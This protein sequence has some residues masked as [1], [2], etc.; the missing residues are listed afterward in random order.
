MSAWVYGCDRCQHV[1][2]RNEAYINQE[3]A[4]DFRL[5]TLLTITAE[6]YINKVWPLCFYISRKNKAKWQMNAP[7]LWVTSRTVI[8]F[9]LWPRHYRGIRA[10]WSAACAPNRSGE[11]AADRQDRHWN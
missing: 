4:G 5:D 1:C 10:R 11:V 6:H 2:P 8:S 3:R 7:G 9:R